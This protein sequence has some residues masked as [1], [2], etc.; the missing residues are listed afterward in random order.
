[1]AALE[2]TAKRDGDVYV[3]NGT[4]MFITNSP[5]A[6]YIIMA[7]YTDK[8][9]GP[10]RGISLFLVDEETPGMTIN[11]LSKLPVHSAETAEI[12]LDECRIPR[13]NL[14]GEEGKG[15]PYLMESLAGGRI[16][17]GAH[18]V[19]IAQAAYEA[20]LEHAKTRIVFGKPLGNFQ[21]IAFKIARMA[22]D[23][24]MARWQTYRSAWLLDQGR[25]CNTEA[26]MTKLFASEAVNRVTT[27]AMQIHGGYGFMMDSPVQR[28][29]RDARIRTVT[30]GAT[31]IQLTVIARSLGLRPQ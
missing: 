27:E 28:Y 13:E 22:M 19:G 2:T 8:S 11:K 10:G 25:E 17:H 26:S 15:F 23:I 21:A 1:V 7:A 3:L 5:F 29:F 16:V 6:D 24:E 4:K 20:S 18:S 31:E 30:E 12:F 9:K 14:V